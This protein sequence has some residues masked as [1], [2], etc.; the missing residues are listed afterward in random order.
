VQALHPP[1]KFEHPPFWNCLSYEIKNY[2]VEVFLNDIT[3]L[4]NFMKLYQLVQTL[5]VGTQRQHGDLISLTFLLLGKYA[6]SHGG[7]YEGYSAVKLH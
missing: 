1:Q 7:N 3:S 2:C 5:L 4:L 6:D